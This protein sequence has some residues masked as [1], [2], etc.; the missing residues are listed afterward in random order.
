[1]DHRSG[2]SSQVWTSLSLTLERKRWPSIQSPAPASS[3]RSWPLSPKPELAE[4][5]KGITVLPVKSLL[6]TK[7]STGQAASPHQ[8]G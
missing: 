5:Q 4:V 1:M 3:A 7:V 6:W 2:P 8:M